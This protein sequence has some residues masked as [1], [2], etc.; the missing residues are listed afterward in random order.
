MSVFSLREQII[1]AIVAKLT[2]VTTAAG[3]TLRRQPALPADRAHL[4]ALLVFPE[5][6]SVRRVNDRAERELTIRLV[7]VAMGTATE[8][9]EP[10]ADRLMTAA[11]AA[12]MTDVGLDGLALGME[13]TDCE[14]QQEDADMEAAALPARYR[15]TYRTLAHD[16]TQKG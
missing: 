3:A 2:P 12:L 16:L 13:E 7:A 4:P 5:A 10:V 11:H 6:E 8:S 1:Q 15:I 14:W 9:P